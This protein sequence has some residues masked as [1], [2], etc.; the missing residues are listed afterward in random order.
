MGTYKKACIH[1]GRL[2]DPDV[3]ACPGCGS[4][5]PLAYR[6]PSCRKEVQP[7]DAMCGGCARSLRVACPHCRQPTWAGEKCEKCG[8][9]LLILCQNPRCGDLQFFDLAR[10]TSCG[11][12][13]VP[14]KFPG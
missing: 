12:K 11:K 14:G 7:G 8:K 13:L 4:R 10:C 6:C 1:C 2:V 3:K 9:G 5:S